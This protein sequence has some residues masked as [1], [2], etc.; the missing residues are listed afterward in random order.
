[1]KHSQKKNTHTK[2]WSTTARALSVKIQSETST[3]ASAQT[4]WATVFNF[5]FSLLTELFIALWLIPCVASS[6]GM[7]RLDS[8]LQ[9]NGQ[10]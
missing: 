6:V 1:M 2:T 8:E 4:M 7:V 5:P 9:Q 3:L 10:V